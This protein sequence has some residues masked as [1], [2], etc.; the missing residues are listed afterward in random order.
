MC[1]AGELQTPVVKQSPNFKEATSTVA[2]IP[3]AKSITETLGAEHLRYLTLAPC[4]CADSLFHLSVAVA[5]GSTPL[6]GR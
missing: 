2:L 4:P 6:T 1:C 3:Q 5:P